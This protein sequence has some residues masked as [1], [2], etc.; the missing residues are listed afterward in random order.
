MIRGTL[1]DKLRMTFKLFLNLFIYH[2]VL[3]LLVLNVVVDGV[4]GNETSN[5]I[6]KNRYKLTRDTNPEFMRCWIEP[7]LHAE[8]I[9]ATERRFTEC[10]TFYSEFLSR[11]MAT[12]IS[13]SRPIRL[14]MRL[15][16]DELNESQN[17]ASTLVD[18]TTE[19]LN[20]NQS[21]RLRLANSYVDSIS[22]LEEQGRVDDA[23]F[24]MHWSMKRAFESGDSFCLEVHYPPMDRFY[25]LMQ[26]LDDIILLEDDNLSI[27]MKRILRPIHDRPVDQ[28]VRSDYSHSS[29]LLMY[30]LQHICRNLGVVEFELTPYGYMATNN[31]GDRVLWHHIMWNWRNTVLIGQCDVYMIHMMRF[32]AQSNQFRNTYPDLFTLADFKELADLL[33]EN[34][35]KKTRK[36][37]F[38]LLNLDEYYDEKVSF[39]F[40]KKSLSFLS[41]IRE[42]PLGNEVVSVAKNLDIRWSLDGPNRVERFFLAQ[43]DPAWLDAYT[44]GAGICSVYWLTNL[45][46]LGLYRTAFLRI[47]DKI[48]TIP[49]LELIA[50]D[51]M[52]AFYVIW[53]ICEEAFLLPF[54][55][56][57]LK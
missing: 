15:I 52:I 28:Q 33:V 9:A 56:T 48:F 19:S 4:K 49:G 38:H 35:L 31:I 11:R 2:T 55:N 42:T 13:S 1:S 20:D 17:R 12:W 36:N 30:L 37:S 45:S 46:S 14:W 7:D 27:S 39:D 29:L 23:E 25:W 3:S 10:E 16:D 43:D 53:K 22:L 51:R 40:Y 44:H 50:S 8:D 18:I 32:A 21:L 34:C 54:V 41:Y 6:I 26:K 5:D 24:H 47:I 57:Q